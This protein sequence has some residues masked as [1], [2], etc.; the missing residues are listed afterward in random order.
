MGGMGWGVTEPVRGLCQAPP[1]IG[2]GFSGRRQV[3]A[4]GTG[5]PFRCC[6]S[7]RKQGARSWAGNQ[8][9]WGGAEEG[10]EGTGP[11]EGQVPRQGPRD[12][13]E[14]RRQCGQRSADRQVSGA[15]LLP[16]QRDQGPDKSVGGGLAGRGHELQGW[17]WVGGCRKEEARV[18][19]WE[20]PAEFRDPQGCEGGGGPEAGPGRAVGGRGLGDL[21]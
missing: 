2:T 13:P 4:A 8:D 21:V 3:W 18:G 9:R 1:L 20:G 17:V 6:F 16:G 5:D 12:P 15:R 14:A 10:G 19:W 7:S 11:G